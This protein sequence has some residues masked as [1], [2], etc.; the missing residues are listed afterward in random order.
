MM[1][2]AAATADT[3]TFRCVLSYFL[4]SFG[5][6]Q[7]HQAEIVSLSFNA[8]GDKLIT[9]SFDHTTKVWDVAAGR[10][11]HTLTGH[12]GEISSVQFSFSGEYCVS[13]SIDQSAM[14]WNISTGVCVETLMGH[15]DEILDVT[16]NTTGSMLVTASADGTARV[17]VL[18]MEDENSDAM[19]GEC[20]AILIGHDGEISKCAFNPQGTK[21]ITASS[22]KTCRVWNA[23]TGEC[24]QM[25]EGHADEIFS[26]A[27]NY[28]G[29]TIITGSKDN[30]CKIWK[31]EEA[32]PS[33]GGAVAEAD[34][35]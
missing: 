18:S 8:G 9:G 23:F 16:F 4:P 32:A 15:S 20:T 31:A 33:A 2:A 27:F 12:T 11:I 34:E 19:T 14:I 10:C 17:H 3:H 7:G 6:F 25:L 22:D 24:L 13:G 1:S 5:F 35:N 28:E 30:T 26:C 21:I 29:D